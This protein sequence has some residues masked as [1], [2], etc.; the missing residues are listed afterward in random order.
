[1]WYDKK[2]KVKQKDRT[3]TCEHC[4]FV[5]PV[6]AGGWIVNGLNQILCNTEGR[7]CINDV[8]KVQKRDEPIIFS[9]DD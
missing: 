9:L 2:K 6:L 8:R 3:V 1:M 7:R 5:H 4:G